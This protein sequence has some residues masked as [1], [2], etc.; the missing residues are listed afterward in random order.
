VVPAL[1]QAA[2]SSGVVVKVDAASKLVAVVGG[3]G[4]VVLVHT[5]QSLHGLRPGQRVSFDAK[6]LRNHT[7]ATNAF[8][9]SGKVRT[10]HVRGIALKASRKQLVL[11]AHGAVLN[12]ALGRKLRVLSSVASGVKVGST[13]DVTLSFDASGNEQAIGVQQIDPTADAGEIEGHVGAEGNG[14][15]AVVSDGVTVTLHVPGWIDLAKL[16]PGE[17]ILAYFV[18]RPDGSFAL[19]AVAGD[20]NEAQANDAQDE[21]GDV[22]ALEQDVQN[23]ED[24][25][26][27]N[28]NDDGDLQLAQAELQ[29]DT[30]G[31]IAQVHEVEQVCKDHVHALKGSGASATELAAASVE[32]QRQLNDEAHQ[33]QLELQ[34]AIKDD[35]EQ[36]AS[37]PT[38]LAQLQSEE[39]SLGQQLNQA[40]Q[41][42]EQDLQAEEQAD[43]I[44]ATEPDTT[45]SGA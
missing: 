8:K 21:Q 23:D 36:L 19:E 31:I 12:L 42:A 38:A 2:P 40:E 27:Q 13:D 15:L 1:A 3:S 5:A 43:G 33:A 10:V 28:Q 7:V 39:Q 29:A 17:Q 9:V 34:A 44:T 32:C 30:A 35:G 14:Q 6:P 37:D 22:D 25:P 26:Q 18:L 16:Q 45:E 20:A 4:R 11:T 41:T 24:Q